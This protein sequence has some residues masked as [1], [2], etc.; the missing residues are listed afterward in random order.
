MTSVLSDRL[1]YLGSVPEKKNGRKRFCLACAG[2]TKAIVGIFSRCR[3]MK[4]YVV[5][6]FIIRGP[7][8]GHIVVVVRSNAKKMRA[9]I[10][11]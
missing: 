4:G 11:R 10:N 7:F 9:T 1:L 8:E 2:G 5:P 3:H 6:S